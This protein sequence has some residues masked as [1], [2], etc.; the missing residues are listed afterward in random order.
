MA[1][2]FVDALKGYEYF[3]NRRG[4]ASLEDISN[5][6]ESIDRSA[7]SQ[8]TYG[9]YQKLLKRGFTSYVP[10]N[11][12][13]VYQTLDKLQVATDRRRY[14]RDIVEIDVT[15]SLDKNAWVPA[16]IIDKSLVGFGMVTFD[17]FQIKPG[18]LIWIHMG[19]YRDIPAL[20]VWKRRYEN[21][22]RFG[23]R[24]L[25]FI[26]NYL[27]SKDKPI[28]FRP[29]GLLV[30][31]RTT[32]DNIDWRELYRIMTKINQLIDATS[33]LLDS[34]ANIANS[35]VKF[36]PPLISSIKFGSPGDVKVKVDLGVAEIIKIALDKAQLW[37]LEKDRLKSENRGNELKNSLLELEVLRNAV[38]F[39]NE[40]IESGVNQELAN[41]LFGL[42]IMKALNIDRLPPNLFES[43]S[44]ENGIL[45]ERLLPAALELVAGDAPNMNVTVQESVP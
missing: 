9:H 16:K 41:S 28:F 40:A 36:A 31:Q 35:K 4:K 8:R 23:V 29:T 22:F 17:K 2:Q 1:A 30:V 24:A 10:I 19:H 45:T 33:D 27:I 13:D 38:K 42:V 37:R 20:I 7:I 25:E 34:I 26:S 18:S 14:A 3:M 6:L 12:F 43:G 5:F 44:L 32:E 15:F 21:H 39:R 11:Q